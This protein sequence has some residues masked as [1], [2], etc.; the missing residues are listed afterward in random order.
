MKKY[1][2]VALSLLAFAVSGLTARAQNADFTIKKVDVEFVPTPD[3]QVNG[4]PIRPTG[5]PKKWAK[6]DVVFDA[7]PDYSEAVTIN[8]Y[9]L[10]GEHLMVGHVDHINVARGR[11]LHS[12]MFISPQALDRIT[13]GNRALNKTSF[14][15]IAATV[16]SGPTMSISNL[17]PGARGEWWS[18]PGMKPEEGLLLNKIETPFAALGWDYYEATKPASGR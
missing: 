1:T 7:V 11:D 9:V 15:N 14:V 5:Q 4:N 13:K 6:V 18:A 12:V 10:L 17:K 2:L 16:G 3:Y 8:Y